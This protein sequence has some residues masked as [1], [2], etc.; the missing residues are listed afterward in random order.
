[1]CTNNPTA[2]YDYKP[3]DDCLTAQNVNHGCQGNKPGDP[4]TTTSAAGS[5]PTGAAVTPTAKP[6]S[7]GKTGLSMGVL[8]LGMLVGVGFIF[9]GL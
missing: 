2:S 7:G 8:S 9:G 1:V 6:G 3:I 4:K 5:T